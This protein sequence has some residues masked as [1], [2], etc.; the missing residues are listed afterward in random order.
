M[1]PRDLMDMPSFTLG[2]TQEENMKGAG[3]GVVKES[4]NG[5]PLPDL[6]FADNIEDP[7]T[8]RKSKRQ[9]MVPSDLVENYTMARIFYQD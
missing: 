8:S 4:V 9:K 6:N 1:V 3:E 7:Q 2:L 5:S